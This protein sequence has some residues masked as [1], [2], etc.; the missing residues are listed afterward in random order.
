MLGSVVAVYITKKLISLD[1]S[2]CE[3]W[4][5]RQGTKLC[6]TKALFPSWTIAV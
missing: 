1:P 3:D 5:E 6:C 4:S 2:L